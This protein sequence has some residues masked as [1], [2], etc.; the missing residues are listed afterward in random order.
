MNKFNKA[1]CAPITTSASF[2]YKTSQE[3]KDIFAGEINEPMYS[4][5]GN[6]TS[7]LLEE[8]IV[9]MDKKAVGAI[10]TSSGMGAISMAVMAICCSGDEIIAIG[11]LFGGSYAFFSQTLNRLNIKVHFFEVD[12]YDGICQ[13]INDKTKIIFCESVGNPNLRLPNLCKIGEIATKNDII[14]MVDNTITPLI[15]NPFEYKSDIVIYSTTKVISGNSSALGGIAVLGDGNIK[16]FN[17]KRYEFMKPFIKK[18]QNKALVG[19]LKKRALRDFGMSANAHSSLQAILGL[20]TLA[21]RMQRLN[22]TTITVAKKLQEYGINVSHPSLKNHQDYNLFNSHF[23]Q[24]CG[25]ILTIDLCSEKKAFEF[26]DT[27][28]VLTITA[29][30]GDSRSL[31]LHM[32]STIYSDFNDK[33]NDFLGI[34]DGLVRI[35]IGL[36]DEDII[37]NDLIKCFKCL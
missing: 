23:K 14:F 21:L 5:M 32:K 27:S 1:I 6:P 34:S 17:T 28:K 10:A 35:S 30:I 36:E 4:R 33:E 25:A 7:C 3:G 18:L 19:C 15:I 26:L 16:K 13:A 24:G 9:Q 8:K 22:K 31:G 11:G 29:N 37:Y 12:D 2:F 20:E